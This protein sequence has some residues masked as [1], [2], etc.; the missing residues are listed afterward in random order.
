MIKID[1][2]KN[3]KAPFPQIKKKRFECPSLL[4]TFKIKF[5]N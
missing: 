1:A 5:K 4:S 3:V 2:H